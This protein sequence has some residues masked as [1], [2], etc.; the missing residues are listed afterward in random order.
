MAPAPLQ[1]EGLAL[2]LI[3][4]ETL[5][6]LVWIQLFHNLLQANLLVLDER[7]A[8]FAR[9]A[10]NKVNL[11]HFP[12]ALLR[13]TICPLLLWTIWGRTALVNEIVPRTLMFMTDRSTSRSVSNDKPSCKMPA[14]FTR[15]SICNGKEHNMILT[16]IPWYICISIIYTIQCIEDLVLLVLLLN[17]GQVWR[18]PGFKVLSQMLSWSF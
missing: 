6:S 10:Q 11:P 8:L 12:D 5:L 4:S 13:T 17:S 7:M 1:A 3:G 14:L 15:K 16:S 9:P 2:P 18:M